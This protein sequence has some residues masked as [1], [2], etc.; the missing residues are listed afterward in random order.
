LRKIG[1]E[2]IGTPHRGI[3]D[4]RNI[5]RLLPYLLGRATAAEV[6]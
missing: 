4:A 2:P 5:A 6:A 3:D 1:L